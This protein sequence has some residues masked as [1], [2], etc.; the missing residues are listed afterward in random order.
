M[1]TAMIIAL[2]SS[3]V[4]YYVAWANPLGFDTYDAHAILSLVVAVGCMCMA[5]GLYVL[6]L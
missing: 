3:L 2:L 4:G 6:S 5:A 1:D